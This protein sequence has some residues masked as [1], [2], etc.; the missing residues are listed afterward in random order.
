MQLFPCS[1][2]LLPFPNMPLSIICHEQK[3]GGGGFQALG[4]AMPPGTGEPTG[5]NNGKAESME[6]ISSDRD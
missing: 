4:D 3:T 2:S 1:A 5:P 6:L